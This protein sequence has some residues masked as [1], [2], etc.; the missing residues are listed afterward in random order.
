MKRDQPKVRVFA[1]VV[2]GTP[3]VD[4]NTPFA[5]EFEADYPC[6]TVAMS[7]VIVGIF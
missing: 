3:R 4:P 5:P 7:K 2:I 1:R 6:T